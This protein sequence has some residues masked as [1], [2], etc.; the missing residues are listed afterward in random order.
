MMA[1]AA[2]AAAAGMVEIGKEDWN[3]DWGC[4]YPTRVAAAEHGG[5]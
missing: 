3:G 5:W 1:A 2:A 4:A